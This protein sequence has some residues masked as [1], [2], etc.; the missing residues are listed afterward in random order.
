M[1]TDLVIAIRTR[2]ERREKREA[3]RPE[4]QAARTLGRIRELAG[5]PGNSRPSVSDLSP[6]QQLDIARKRISEDIFG[7]GGAESPPLPA[8]LEGKEASPARLQ[9]RGARCLDDTD[10]NSQ[11]T[12]Q[13]SLAS[14][15]SNGTEG[16][17]DTTYGEFPT[18][19]AMGDAAAS[20]FI[21]AQNTWGESFGG[22]SDN[23]DGVGV[24][25]TPVPRKPVRITPTSVGCSTIGAPTPS[26]STGASDGR[27]GEAQPPSPGELAA[28]CDDYSVSS[29]GSSIP[30][31]PPPGYPPYEESSPELSLRRVDDGDVGDSQLALV[32]ESKLGFRHSFLDSVKRDWKEVQSAPREIRSDREIMLCALKQSDSAMHYASPVLLEDVEYVM[33]AVM[34]NGR[35]LR[36]A[37]RDLRSDRAIVQVFIRHFHMFADA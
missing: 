14:V 1:I 2:K 16:S 15:H 34:L 8:L 19:A 28:P 24:S 35:A 30:P 37:S 3:R 26:S 17:A 29:E 21:G 13:T 22:P 27:R 33:S 4:V 12:G 31:P 32:E 10:G 25:P 7:L 5:I 11:A 6:S 36:Y 9:L 23:L 20:S 18:T